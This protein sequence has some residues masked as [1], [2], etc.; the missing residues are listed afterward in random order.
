M[1]RIMRYRFGKRCRSHSEGVAVW[2]SGCRADKC[3]CQLTLAV[4]TIAELIR[5]MNVGGG[6]V[7]NALGGEVRAG[8]TD[9][10]KDEGK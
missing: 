6:A 9:L 2:I 1:M 3:D 8:Q 5:L 10:Y 7:S 4:W